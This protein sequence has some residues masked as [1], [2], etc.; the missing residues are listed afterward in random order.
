MD[1]I[2]LFDIDRTLFDIVKNRKLIFAELSQVSGLPEKVV[3]DLYT[4]YRKT[5]ANPHDW[6]PTVYLGILSKQTNKSIEE[7]TS[8]FYTSSLYETCLFPDVVP[9]LAQLTKNHDLG[10][11]SE[12][13]YNNQIAKI[14]LAKIDYF[15]SKDYL[16]VFK[17]K[18]S[19][20]SLATLP[21]ATI[22]DDLLTECRKIKLMSTLNPI[23]INRSDLSSAED[24]PTIH[25]LTK[26]V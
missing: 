26:M 13:H 6:D 18:T 9:A 20:E 5:F 15:F 23:W 17:R 10:I 7:L 8:A 3:T 2:I 14:T 11:F 21:S 1:N 22:V 19:P 4:D 24:V 12:G 16:F 25:E